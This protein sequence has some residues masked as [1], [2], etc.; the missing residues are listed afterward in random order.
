MERGQSGPRTPAV[1]T[2]VAGGRSV[3]LNANNLH[4]ALS[5]RESASDDSYEYADS[6]HD[7]ADSAALDNES[8][9]SSDYSYSTSSSSSTPAVSTSPSD[10]ELPSPIK[11]RPES[12][13]PASSSMSPTT[14][15]TLRV[16]DGDSELNASRETLQLL[17]SVVHARRAMQPAS[18][19]DLSGPSLSLSLDLGAVS[20]GDVVTLE[21]LAT[22][23]TGYAPTVGGFAAV[24]EAQVMPE[25]STTPSERT[26]GKRRR[27]AMVEPSS[28]PFNSTLDSSR[29]LLQLAQFRSTFEL[30]SASK[31]RIP[32][33]DSNS[34]SELSTSIGSMPTI[35]VDGG[36]SD[37]HLDP[38]L[39]VADLEALAVHKA[40]TVDETHGALRAFW[41]ETADNDTNVRY[42]I[43]QSEGTRIKA[44]NL[45]KIVHHLTTE[46]GAVDPFSFFCS[47]HYIVSSEMLL[48]KLVEKFRMPEVKVSSCLLA[49][50]ITDAVIVPAKLTV[51]DTIRFWLL[52]YFVDDFA[53]VPEHYERTLAF[54]QA[55]ASSADEHLLVRSPAIQLRNFLGRHTPEHFRADPAAF[56]AGLDMDDLV[57]SKW[58][59]D[60][61]DALDTIDHDLPVVQIH[62][63][64]SL[65]SSSTNLP[66][67][68]TLSATTLRPTASESD[69]RAMSLSGSTSPVPQREPSPAP[70]DSRKRSHSIS[71]SAQTA[72]T[73]NDM[74]RLS[75]SAIK[76]EHSEVASAA[77]AALAEKDKAADGNDDDDLP[78]SMFK[79]KFFGTDDLDAPPSFS[80]AHPVELARQL[81]LVESEH[82]AAIRPREFHA[83]AWSKASMAHRALNILRMIESFNT[84]VSW[85]S[86]LVIAPQSRKE[87]VKALTQLVRMAWELRKL[88][89]YHSLMAILAAL[90]SHA[91]QRL[92]E[93]WAGVKK[94]VLTKLAS[95]NT[96]MSMSK[97]FKNYRAEVASLPPGSP[98]IPYLGIYLSDFTYIDNMPT[99]ISDCPGLVNWSKIEMLGKQISGMI[100]H[101]VAPYRFR[102]VPSIR[103]LFDL[104]AL[105]CLTSDQLLAMS[106]A[107]EP[108]A[109][110]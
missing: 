49:K 105:A 55:V 101:Q 29:G 68:A 48:A 15:P 77:A 90:N 65:R 88:A 66:A 80:K 76:E 109:P 27:A 12:R 67:L 42:T 75:M 21:E 19:G 50:T 100:E 39:S 17:T 28:D 7:S 63:P 96:V 5:R 3:S 91:V 97:S 11:T 36:S 13:S 79:R 69:V 20:T 18:D 78:P 40:K 43:S 81:C 108:P 30:W 33:H 14:L 23:T 82:W 73:P 102:V 72:V 46:S 85:C 61:R 94:K 47:Y 1:G 70:H 38:G 86:G 45:N 53:R 92:T 59:H 24:P 57:A 41:D 107:R 4:A 34:H 71:L 16:L 8:D 56:L 51:L 103:K 87:R 74:L 25:L 54:I 95:L 104:Y 106:K 98:L 6:L 83:L 64:A 37:S 93:T 52:S 32:L 84:T 99:F 26:A 60:P 89:N 62:S 35:V 10:P 22:P 110:K 58:L 2:G 9:S 44:A 31:P